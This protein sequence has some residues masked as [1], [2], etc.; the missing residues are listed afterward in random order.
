MEHQQYQYHHG[1]QAPIPV[2]L[3]NRW[4]SKLGLRILSILLTAAAVG[5]SVYYSQHWT[6]GALLMMGP[7]VGLSQCL[8][9]AIGNRFYRQPLLFS[10]IG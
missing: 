10:G 3:S 5:A 7:P 2:A 9:L 4:W 1:E 8:S 6:I